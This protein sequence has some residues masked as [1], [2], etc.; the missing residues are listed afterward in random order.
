MELVGRTFGK[1]QAQKPL[2]HYGLGPAFEGLHVTLGKSCVV[3][4]L[5]D[6]M[7]RDRAAVESFRTIAGNISRISHESI[8][9]VQEVIYEPPIVGYVVPFSP[10]VTLAH[11]VASQG[12]LPFPEFVK[13]FRSVLGA[14]AALH[15]AGVV[16]RA[17]RPHSI[18]LSSDGGVHLID[19]GV[20]WDL[21]AS[22]SAESIA[23]AHYV[24]PEEGIRGPVDARADLYSLGATMF[25][26]LTGRTPHLE[27]EPIALIQAHAHK[28]PMPPSQFRPDIP[29][30][31]NSLVLKLME[32]QPEARA[33]LSYAMGIIDPHSLAPTK[34][35][36][37]APGPSPQRASQLAE[38]PPPPSNKKALVLGGGVVGGLVVLGLIIALAVPSKPARPPSPPP[39]PTKKVEAAAAPTDESYY[40]EYFETARKFKAEGK[41]QE[42]LTQ[43]EQAQRFR[44]T[45][46]LK[47]LLNDI[48][49]EIVF[50]QRSERAKPHYEKIVAMAAKKED[51]VAVCFECEEF[52]R[53]NSDL[54]YAEEIKGIFEKAKKE[55]EE[56]QAKG[57][58]TKLPPT[59][60]KPR[61][62]QPRPPTPRPPQPQPPP[63]PVTLGA[64]F[65]KAKALVGE[66]K[67]SEAK[68][69]LIDM[70]KKETNANN[71]RAIGAEFYKCL[72][73]EDARW[74]PQ[75]DGKDLDAS[76][77]VVRLSDSD[78]AA[79]KDSSEITGWARE[80]DIAMLQIKNFKGGTGITVECNIESKFQDPHS[81]AIRVDFQ[82][83]NAYKDF[84]L[85]ERRGAL[86][87]V[88]K[89]EESE[90]AT[91]PAQG[92]FKRWIRLTLVVEGDTLYGFAN[93][94]LICALP[95]SEVKLGEDIRILI[96]G[97]SARLR[98]IQ[99][100]F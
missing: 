67:F 52:L 48:R 73:G 91:V 89:K 14:V 44:Q 77:N 50:L 68:P 6:V 9:L 21:R 7:R 13:V 29:A 8:P 85:S 64:E 86:K 4:I 3:K 100:R 55:V 60:V 58:I 99:A 74:K 75:F 51:P 80:N 63:P 87:K 94:F 95:A 72:M 35:V 37:R 47:A 93:D 42:A 78:I 62:G 53:T 69:I 16:H 1:F 18:I 97:C 61:P 2:P 81:V 98:D 46:E 92:I 15:Q 56:K 30:S 41:L 31:Y 27:T 71:R 59:P 5:P 22:K 11:R 10:G 38:P 12:R 79:A 43:A 28:S 33:D 39:V 66:K 40:Q 65:D 88:F 45:D 54:S 84:Y 76:F 24:S 34:P 17:I 26:A 57:P 20:Q 36:T 82:A 70:L 49:Q 90:L 32:R 96:A 19:A 83:G 23:S 25:Y